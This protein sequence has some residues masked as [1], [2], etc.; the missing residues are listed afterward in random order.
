MLLLIRQRAQVAQTRVP[1]GTVVKRLD[2]PEYQLP[3]RTGTR[4]TIVIQALRLQRVE[5]RFHVC[6]IVTV[7][8]PTHAL[9][10]PVRR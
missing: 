9:L 3:D 5:E 6:I 1:A 8:P 4:Q 7:A 10:D 2:V